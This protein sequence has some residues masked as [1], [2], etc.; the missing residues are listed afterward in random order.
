MAESACS[1]T[2]K[3]TA[4][5]FHRLKFRAA[6]VVLTATYLFHWLYTSPDLHALLVSEMGT[7]VFAG[8][9]LIVAV[10]SIV[11]NKV[12]LEALGLI[13]GEISIIMVVCAVIAAALMYVQRA[14]PVP[15]TLR[16]TAGV[17]F[18]ALLAGTQPKL[19]VAH[20]MAVE[21]LFLITICLVAY[22]YH[23][24]RV[25]QHIRSAAPL[26]RGERTR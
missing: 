26:P 17:S 21:V 22:L 23:V 20:A 19:L 2:V 13:A 9:A 3:L 18:Y 5:E 11:V 1:G 8:S 16:G 4:A 15:I 12:H 7:V 24:I 14:N 10:L 6:F 25:A